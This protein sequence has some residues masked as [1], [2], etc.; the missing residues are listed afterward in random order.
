[1]GSTRAA[2]IDC[3]VRR[4]IPSLPSFQSLSPFRPLRPF[5]PFQSFQSFRSFPWCGSYADIGSLAR[6]AFMGR[7][8]W[9]GRRH[10]A[11]LIAPRAGSQYAAARCAA[12]RR[13]VLAPA[14]ALSSSAASPAIAYPTDLAVGLS[15]R[16]RLLPE[17]CGVDALPLQSLRCRYT[18]GY[19]AK[20]R[21]RALSG[22]VDAAISRLRKAN[23]DLT[24]RYW[25]H[26]YPRNRGVAAHEKTLI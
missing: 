9:L 25:A 19:A 11:T 8:A 6:H 5:Q 4:S 10:G 24:F 20:R 23:Q 2:R 7:R 21:G 13:F 16:Y 18:Y 12:V 14:V 26:S 22:F 15:A 1:M 3:G 17:R